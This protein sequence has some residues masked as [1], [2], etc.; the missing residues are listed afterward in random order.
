MADAIILP[1]W[2]QAVLSDQVW[3]AAV[4]LQWN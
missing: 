3:F 4:V 1:L 2:C